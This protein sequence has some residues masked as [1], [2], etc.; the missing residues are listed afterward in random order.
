MGLHS[1]AHAAAAA[2]LIA[3]HP[4]CSLQ[5][6]VLPLRLVLQICPPVANTVVFLDAYSRNLHTVTKIASSTR[7]VVAQRTH[8]LRSS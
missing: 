3:K 2:P 6:P 7:P 4:G 8:E 1:D 5:L